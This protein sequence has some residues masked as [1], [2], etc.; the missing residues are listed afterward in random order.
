MILII[1]R[2]YVMNY[3]VGWLIYVARRLSIL[4]NYISFARKSL[5]F[6]FLVWVMSLRL[7]RNIK[8]LGNRIILPKLHPIGKL[9][10][11]HRQCF[12]FPRYAEVII[13]LSVFINRKASGWVLCQ[14][15]NTS[16]KSSRTSIA[17]PDLSFLDRLSRRLRASIVP[18]SVRLR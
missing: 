9:S 13:S 2:C 18:L 3:L 15:S 10:N 7:M 4:C 12:S 5:I 8:H 6:G 11:L 16:K 14:K 17:L 1:H